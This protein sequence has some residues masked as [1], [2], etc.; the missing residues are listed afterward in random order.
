M[1]SQNTEMKTSESSGSTSEGSNHGDALAEWDESI[2]LHDY[3]QMFD[4]DETEEHHKE[5]VSQGMDATS[6][7]AHFMAPAHHLASGRLDM[8]SL[9]YAAEQLERNV[10]PRLSNTSPIHQFTVDEIR[11][12]DRQMQQQNRASNP[13]TACQSEPSLQESMLD[14]L[15]RDSLQR[16]NWSY[17]TLALPLNQ[18]HGYPIQTEIN[19]L[20][21]A[22]P[23]SGFHG[24]QQLPS[25]ENPPNYAL[26]SPLL[27]SNRSDR[28]YTMPDLLDTYFAHTLSEEKNSSILSKEQH[29]KKP[30]KKRTKIKSHKKEI[31]NRSTTNSREDLLPYVQMLLSER[32][33]NGTDKNIPERPLLPLSPYNY[34]YRD[35]R[36]N[37]INGMQTDNDP[38]PAPGSDFS[39]SKMRQLLYQH[40]FDD[41]SKPKRSHRKSHGKM[42]FE[43][44]AGSTFLFLIV[45]AP[46]V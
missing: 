8:E 18:S 37:I 34:Y 22:Q 17:P 13:H 11:L 36:D 33:D 19:I 16:H 21:F 15:H 42:D 4:M 29:N 24:G 5:V 2:I 43:R 20:P 30:P 46:F 10:H 32:M 35:E 14:P 25:T 39:D 41:P 31:Q 26:P 44:Y 45:F 6:S 27:L 12:L 28:A 9:L 1:M 3:K 23:F 40:W 38:L 7:N